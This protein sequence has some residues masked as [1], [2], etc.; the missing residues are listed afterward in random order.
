MLERSRPKV[1]TWL[2]ASCRLADVMLQD[3]VVIVHADPTLAD[4]FSKERVRDFPFLH[5]DH[6]V[7]AAAPACPAMCAPCH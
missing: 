1:D 6:E 2:E 5:P 7:R 4:L 3:L